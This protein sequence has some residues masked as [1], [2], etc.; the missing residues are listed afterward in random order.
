MDC[1]VTLKG[2]RS[3]K[4]ALSTARAGTSVDFGANAPLQDT[5]FAART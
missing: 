5:V 1:D 4:I 3:S 2:T